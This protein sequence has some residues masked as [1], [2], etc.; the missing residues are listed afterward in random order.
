MK[1]LPSLL[2]SALLLGDTLYIRAEPDIR[3]C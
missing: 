1:N 2:D 3:A